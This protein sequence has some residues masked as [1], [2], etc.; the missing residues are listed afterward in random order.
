MKT[1]LKLAIVLILC[2]FVTSCREKPSTAPTQVFKSFDMSLIITE[3]GFQ[4]KGF[5]E[6]GTTNAATGEAKYIRSGTFSSAEGRF[7]CYA[8]FQQIKKYYED[9]NKISVS[10]E[11]WDPKTEEHPKY[12]VYIAMKYNQNKRHGEM[13][14]WLFPSDDY[15]KIGFALYYIEEPM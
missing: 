15:T 8:I 10:Q 3:A 4:A 11:G 1:E 2:A 13:N 5:S 7:P 12:P 9:S 14:L 6:S